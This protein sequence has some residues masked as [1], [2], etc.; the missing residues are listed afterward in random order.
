MAL[1]ALAQLEE[2]LLC[3]QG[4]RGSSPLSSTRQN[5]PIL[6]MHRGA[7]AIRVLAYPA[8]LIGCVKSG[9]VQ[10]A[11]FPPGWTPDYFVA[12]GAFMKSFDKDLAKC[13]ERVDTR[14]DRPGPHGL[15]R[16]E[17][18]AFAQRRHG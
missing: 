4:V 7:R 9:A 2:H 15:A 12:L 14:L 13:R 5:T 6:M 8:A 11:L 3:K 18:G 16:L 17:A 10:G 1:G